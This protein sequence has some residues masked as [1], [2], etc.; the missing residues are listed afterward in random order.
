MNKPIKYCSVDGCESEVHARGWCGKH[1]MRSRRYG[2]PHAVTK[3]YARDIEEAFSLG[4]EW[5]NECLIWVRSKTS[6][7]YGQ[8]KFQGKLHFA[9]IYAWE[10]VNGVV[11][12]GMKVD[13]KFHCDPACC[14]VEHLRLATHSQNIS[15]RSGVPAHNKTSGIRNVSWDKMN[16]KWRVTVVKS[17][18]TKCFGRY[19]TIEEAAL[20]AEQARK[21]LFGE[22]SGRG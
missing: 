13:H 21:E 18:K 11:P 17:G 2:D 15:H 1:Y 8:I 7:G 10:R 9:H 3:K 4:T 14:N 22:F 20:V 6:W 19:K 5:K 16:K 12:P